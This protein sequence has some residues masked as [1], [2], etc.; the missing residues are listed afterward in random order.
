MTFPRLAPK[1]VGS[2]WGEKRDRASPVCLGTDRRMCVWTWLVHGCVHVFAVCM[3]TCERVL[4][5]WGMDL[6]AIPTSL[7]MEQSTGNADD[8]CS[9]VV[10]NQRTLVCIPTASEQ[11]GVYRAAEIIH[12]SGSRPLAVVCFKKFLAGHSFRKYPVLCLEENF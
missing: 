6:K 3:G 10:V 9:L 4:W 11:E 2:E 5:A 12:S 7:C 8:G 1:S